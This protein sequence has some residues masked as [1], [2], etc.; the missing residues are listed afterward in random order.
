MERQPQTTVGRI[1]ITA[2]DDTGRWIQDLRKQDLTLYEDGIQRLVLSLQ[3]DVDTPISMGIVVDTSG[4]MSW[5]LAAAEAALQH[6]VRTLNPNDQFFLIAFSD[7]A[8]LLQGFTDNPADLNRAIG[9]LHAQG[10][11]A[12]Y[13]AVVQGLQKV[14]TRPMA[15]KGAAG[16]DRWYRQ[17]QLELAQRRHPGGAPRRGFD[18]YR[19]HRH[20]RCAGDGDGTDD[21]SAD[22]RWW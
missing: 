19:R 16:N 4:S 10:R 11:T 12:L 8:F 15:Q 14:D 18:L 21:D 9:L 6:F 7:R 3:R 2:T 20:Y 5:R 22:V 17:C 1:S 13:D